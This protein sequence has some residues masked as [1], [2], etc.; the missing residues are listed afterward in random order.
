MGSYEGKQ[1]FEACMINYKYPK[2]QV[3]SQEQ[4][5]R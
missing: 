1:I 2:F 4:L 3:S 5:V